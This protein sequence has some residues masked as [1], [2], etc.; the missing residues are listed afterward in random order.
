M[1]FHHESPFYRQTLPIYW[2][3][4][5]WKFNQSFLKCIKKCIVWSFKKLNFF[6][7]IK[8]QILLIW[9][10]HLCK[11]YPTKKRKVLEHLFISYKLTKK[12]M[13]WNTKSMTKNLSWS[14][15]WMDS[16]YITKKQILHG[17]DEKQK[18][19]N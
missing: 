16:N 17:Y 5:N 2:K 8:E 13:R 7:L 9:Y 19:K 1:E 11:F 18:R 3:N 14:F 15:L 4:K 12:M 6:K 10:L